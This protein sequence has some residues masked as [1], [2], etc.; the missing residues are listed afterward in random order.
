[1]LAIFGHGWQNFGGKLGVNLG[2]L[3]QAILGVPD[4]EPNPQKQIL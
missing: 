4:G 3:I 2:V 1:M